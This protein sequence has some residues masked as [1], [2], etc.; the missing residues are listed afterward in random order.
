MRWKLVL[1][2]RVPKQTVSDA[3]LVPIVFVCWKTNTHREKKEVIISSY[4]KVTL[5]GIQP[6]SNQESL[7]RDKQQ[8]R[9]CS[10]NY[11][12]EQ[13]I[14]YIQVLLNERNFDVYRG[15]EKRKPKKPQS[16]NK[17]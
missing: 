10:T 11:G 17:A 8:S 5:K 6:N 1:W 2:I 7:E 14:H 15:Q 9:K 16:I 3:V 4:Y 13:Y 12:K